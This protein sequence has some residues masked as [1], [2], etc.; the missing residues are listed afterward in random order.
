MQQDEE[1]DGVV[2]VFVVVVFVVVVFVVFA[3]FVV[4]FVFVVIIV[5]VVDIVAVAQQLL[6]ASCTWKVHGSVSLIAS[7]QL[8]KNPPP[9]QIRQ[10]CEEGS[11]YG[12]LDICIFGFWYEQFVVA[13]PL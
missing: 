5:V 8:A 12:Y 11:E 7:V 6:H 1:Y 10:T 4:V 9:R 13:S 3:V 2:V